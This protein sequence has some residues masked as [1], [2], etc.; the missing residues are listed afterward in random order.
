MAYRVKDYQILAPDWL[1]SEKFDIAA[2]L[3]E[4]GSR[5]QVPAMLQALL[6]DRFQMKLHHDSKEF[7]VYGLVVA[8]GGMKMKESQPDAANP[9]ADAT[10]G[11]VDVQV[12]GGRDGTSVNFGHGSNFSLGPGK[13]EGTKLTMQNLADMLA[14][15]L[16]RP[17]V[18]M[19]GLKGSYD[20]QFNVPEEEFRIMTIRAAISAG[21]SLPPQALRLVDGAT[22][23]ALFG[24]LETVGLKLENRKAPVDVLV[25]DH[26]EKAPAEN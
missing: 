5:D 10:K 9:G 22:D 8:K 2:K 1:A 15:F 25:I 24:G 17:V 11:T 23:D 13:L 6:A 4:G 3:P 16:D 12:T 14:R 19:T 20:F 26:M 18:D 7:P 21:V